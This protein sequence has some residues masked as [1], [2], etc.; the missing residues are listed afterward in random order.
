MTFID[1]MFSYYGLP[2]LLPNILS[3]NL[4]IRKKSIVKDNAKFQTHPR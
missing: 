4:F 1:S 2:I 3:K